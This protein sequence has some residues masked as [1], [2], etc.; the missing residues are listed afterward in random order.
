MKLV[1]QSRSM[2]T[3]PS[4]ITSINT[5]SAPSA[6]ASNIKLSEKAAI[7]SDGVVESATKMEN[8]AAENEVPQPEHQKNPQPRP[9]AILKK[10][11]LACRLSLSA[12][13]RQSKEG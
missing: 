6:T 3:I 9:Q 4:F 10:A 11:L 5:S 8:D 13:L 7:A 12:S 1:W 2:V